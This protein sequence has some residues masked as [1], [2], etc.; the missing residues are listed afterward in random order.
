[1][2]CMTLT[3]IVVAESD[4]PPHRPP[5]SPISTLLN[6]RYLCASLHGLAHIEA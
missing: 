3:V 4:S 1:M 2:K 6:D 5:T